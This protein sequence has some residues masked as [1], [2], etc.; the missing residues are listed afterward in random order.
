[1][2][3]VGATGFFAV[4]YSILVW[5]ILF[6]VFPRLWS[7]SHK[8][9]YV[10]AADFVRGRFGSHALALAVA[11]TGIV[12]TMPYIALQLVGMEVVLAGLGLHLSVT[13][14]GTSSSFHF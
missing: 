2:F 8:N 4:P 14:A 10:T 5:P 7:V 11:V 9:G 13:L 12:A 1:M 3:G 6:V